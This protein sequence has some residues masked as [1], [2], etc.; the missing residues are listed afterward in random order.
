M[1]RS[2][3]LFTQL[4]LHKILL[5]EVPG[6]WPCR[7]RYVGQVTTLSDSYFSVTR[8]SEIFAASFLLSPPRFTCP[9]I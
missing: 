1:L 7:R 3:W 5:A 8:F 9:V 2:C 4:Q 6:S